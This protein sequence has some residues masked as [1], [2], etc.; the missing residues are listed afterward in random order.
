MTK[1]ENQQTAVCINSCL[2]YINLHNVTNFGLYNKLMLI[3]QKQVLELYIT[4][5]EH[6]TLTVS[7]Y[8]TQHSLMQLKQQQCNNK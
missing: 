5:I 8:L 4:A 6:K 3:T 1:Q 7:A 2:H